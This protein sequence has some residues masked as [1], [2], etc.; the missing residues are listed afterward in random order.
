MTD[1]VGA[2]GYQPAV[3]IRPVN[4]EQDRYRKIWQN[5]AYR[6]DAPGEAKAL[7]FLSQAKPKH[8]AEI[9]DFG[10]GTG[11]GGLMLALVGGM[12]VTM[13]DFADNCLDAEVRQACERQ[14]DRI[15]FHMHDLTRP[16]PFAA[17][18]GYCTDVLEHIPE[19]DVMTVLKNILSASRHVFFNI[20]TVRDNLGKMLSDGPLHLT[21][22]PMA[23][24]IE[25]LGE[26][27][28]V[29][30]WSMEDVN[31]CCI[32]CTAWMDGTSIVEH[33]ILNI[34]QEQIR[35]NVK[36][37]IA[38]GWQQVTPHEANYVEVMLVGGGPSL[39]EHEDDI[40][41]LREQGTKLI[42]LNGAYNW[43]LERDLKPSAVVVVDARPFNA[44][45]TH[46]VVDDC[47]YLVASQVDPATLDGLPK[48]RTYLWHTTAEEVKDILN[49]QYELWFGIPGGSTV[50]LRALPLLRMLGF[51]RFHLFGCDSCINGIHHAYSQPENDDAP[52]VPVTVSDGRIFRC[53]PWMVAQAQEFIDLIKFMGDEMEIA[54]YGDGL[55]NHILV[56]GSKLQGE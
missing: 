29:V 37:N 25:R 21:V 28:A 51:K 42:C 19:Q 38:Q 17:A 47:K 30:H 12:R 2:L 22:K 13:L 56:T 44:R 35:A 33:G 6:A 10:C 15:K 45:F 3:S 18:Y 32:Y 11:R 7:L 46:P 49:E 43:C 4:P 26:L 23:W 48:D 9:I 24:W 8:D 55:L 41:A 54:T 16:V 50:L 36:H 34:E 14:P 31:D 5:E 40:R 39:A 52:I 27:S 53:H 20:S 1:A